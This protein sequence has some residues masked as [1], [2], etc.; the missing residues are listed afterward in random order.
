MFT[1]LG[2]L[3]ALGTEIREASITFVSRDGSPQFEVQI[4]GTGDSIQGLPALAPGSVMV[5][6]A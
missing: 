5:V 4:V 2:R 3:G 1:R 6:S